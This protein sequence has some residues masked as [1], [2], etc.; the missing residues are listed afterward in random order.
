MAT[1]QERQDQIDSI[2]QYLQWG[3]ENSEYRDLL[4]T[5]FIIKE[6]IDGLKEINSTSLH[7]LLISI[8]ALKNAIL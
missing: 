6:I 5:H 4:E 8:R 1:P 7:S 2:A 3:I